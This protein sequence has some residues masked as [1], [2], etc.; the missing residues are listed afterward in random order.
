[1]ADITPIDRGRHPAGQGRWLRAVALQ[2]A[3][4]LVTGMARPSDE[5]ATFN[6]RDDVLAYADDFHAW[7]LGEAE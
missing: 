1:M 2:T 6:H 7:L 5:G 4:Q 3:A